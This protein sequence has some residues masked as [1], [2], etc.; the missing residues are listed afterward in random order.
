MA[1]CDLRRDASNRMCHPRCPTARLRS[2]V[3]V[4]GGRP[5]P[6]QASGR[7]G[8]SRRSQPGPGDHPPIVTES[9][10]SWRVLLLTKRVSM[11]GNLAMWPEVGGA[12]A[13]DAPTLAI[14]P[15]NCLRPAQAAA[16]GLCPLRR[17]PGRR[18]ERWVS[19]R[20]PPVAPRP[21][22]ENFAGIEARL[23]GRGGRGSRGLSEPRPERLPDVKRYMARPSYMNIDDEES[24]DTCDCRADAGLGPSGAASPAVTR[25]GHGGP[26]GQGNP[27]ASAAATMAWDY[28]FPVT[29]PPGR[30]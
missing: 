11:H 22:C 29:S 18:S 10:L 9:T 26:G 4:S 6:W 25:A 23:G 17:F 27:P 1:R 12:G 24:L 8:G 15:A 13:S 3:V 14:E 16:G 2:L 19:Y 21:I 28:A 5:P 7:V 30:A 20:A